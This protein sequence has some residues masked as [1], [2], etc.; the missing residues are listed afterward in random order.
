MGRKKQ[1]VRKKRELHRKT[2]MIIGRAVGEV[3]IF[4]KAHLKNVQKRLITYEDCLINKAVDIQLRNGGRL[5]RHY[6]PVHEA[7]EN[8]CTYFGC[9]RSYWECT[10]IQDASSD[11]D[12]DDEAAAVC[13]EIK[14]TPGRWRR[15]LE[16]E[17]ES[18]RVGKVSMCDF[19]SNLNSTSVGDGDLASCCDNDESL[20]DESFSDSEEEFSDGNSGHLSADEDFATP[21]QHQSVKSTA[22]SPV[23]TNLV[24][25]GSWHTTT[26]RE[27]RVLDLNTPC[28]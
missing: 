8:V 10:C 14:K 27:K 17:K 4:A 18:A 16:L 13:I 24:V 28:K 11:E 1:G 15:L 5:P 12:D 20:S 22:V 26:M 19:I 7:L 2:V 9:L 23:D 21:T 25:G 3:D 6:Y